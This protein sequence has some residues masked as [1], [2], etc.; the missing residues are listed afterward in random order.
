[1]ALNEVERRKFKSKLNEFFIALEGFNIEWYSNFTCCN[2]CGHEEIQTLLK[3]ENKICSYVFYHNQEEESLSA[4]SDKCYLN[5]NIL[6]KDVEI[7]KEI[8][9]SFGSSWDGDNTTKIVIP[10]HND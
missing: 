3:E 2:T 5:H 10:F 4:G 1:M 9:K 7:I 8:A 6:P